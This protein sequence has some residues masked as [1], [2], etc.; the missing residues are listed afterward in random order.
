MS[1]LFRKISRTPFLYPFLFAVYPV[2]FLWGQ[3]R[4]SSV[5]GWDLFEVLAVVVVVTG[6]VFA[7]FAWALHDT[8]RGAL[9]TAIIMLLALTYGRAAN[10]FHVAIGMPEHTAILVAWALFAVT[11]VLV[12]RGLT[13][14]ERATPTL[15]LIATLLIVMNIVPTAASLGRGAAPNVSARTD[16]PR[17]ALHAPPGQLRDVY[18]VIFD[19]YAGPRTLSDLYDYDDTPFVSSLREDGFTVVDNALANYPQTTHSLASSL[20]MTT[21]DDLAQKVGVDSSDRA[22]LQAS[23]AN[24]TVVR[25]FR[26]L[27]YKYEHVGSWWSISWVDP[28]ADQNFVYGGVPEFAKVFLDTTI[29][30]T[31]A[32]MTKLDSATFERQAYDRIGF[33]EESLK[34]IAQDPA[35]TFTFAHFLLPHPPY[36][37]APDGSYVPP[38]GDRSDEQAYIDQLQY[39]N[40]FIVSL[41][42]ELRAAPG[43]A[44]IIV[45][46]SDEGPHPPTL[47]IPYE[48]KASWSEASIQDLGRKLRILNAYY[49]PGLKHDPIYADITPVN[50]FRVILD[51]YFGA[52]LPLLPDRTFIYT[53]YDH[54]YRFEDVTDKLRP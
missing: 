11:A 3:N 1:A 40:G 5:P 23:F 26:T 50:T 41:E 4:G 16:F 12:A 18:Y 6:V 47:D 48:L 51:S 17:G 28:T 44:P 2:V 25:A 35:P 21:L 27:G 39:T 14:P 24:P 43:P 53:D 46:Q 7:L 9:A 32:Q 8:S 15:N 45:I 54:P 49:L 34:Q 42:Q 30:P 37:F 29:E 38:G 36:V 22:P 31:V 20:N 13:S 33:Q 10:F 19:R 52:D